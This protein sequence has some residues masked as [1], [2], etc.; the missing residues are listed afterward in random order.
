M[1]YI[2]SSSKSPDFVTYADRRMQTRILAGAAL[3]GAI[4]WLFVILPDLRVPGWNIAI[5]DF[6]AIP[7]VIAFLLFGLRG[8][9][10]TSA[11]GT[12]AIFFSSE[13]P[14]PFVGAVSKFGAIVP[15]ILTVYFL[16]KMLPDQPP[17]AKIFE[18]SRSYVKLFI[19]AVFVRCIAMFLINLFISVPFMLYYFTN[20][21]LSPSE[22]PAAFYDWLWR[23]PMENL[24]G[25]SGLLNRISAIQLF[26]L[27]VVGIFIFNIWLSFLELTISYFVIFPSGLYREFGAW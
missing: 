1:V 5:I 2:V 13:E 20:T 14:V 21:W 17:T 27:F 24:F 4:S 22:V 9:I 23:W 7:W 8:G 6:V 25:Q 15:M 3:L 18:S 12:I 26:L 19:P 11:I 10:L 16:M